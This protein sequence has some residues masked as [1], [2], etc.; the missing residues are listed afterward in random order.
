MLRLGGERCNDFDLNDVFCKLSPAT[1]DLTGT[2]IE[3]R[4]YNQSHDR[5]SVLLGNSIRYLTVDGISRFI[6]QHIE[7]SS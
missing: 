5:D 3:S 6:E 7:T 1:L 2:Y 4:S